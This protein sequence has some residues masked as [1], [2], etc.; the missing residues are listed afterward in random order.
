MGSITLECG[1]RAT[2]FQQFNPLR[3]NKVSECSFKNVSQLKL[4]IPID[5]RLKIQ[6]LED[7]LK[8][9]T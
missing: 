8:S 9:S 5:L 6:N 7:E 4:K 1:T 3:Y 2:S